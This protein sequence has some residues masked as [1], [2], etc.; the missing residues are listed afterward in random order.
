MGFKDIF[1]K[2]DDNQPAQNQQKIKQHQYINRH[3]RK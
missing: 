2:S 3:N 1:I